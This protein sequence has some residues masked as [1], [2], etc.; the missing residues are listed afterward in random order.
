[1]GTDKFPDK[2][3]CSHTQPHQLSHITSYG[4][5]STNNA[6]NN[7]TTHCTSH[8]DWSGLAYISERRL[9]RWLWDI[10]HRSRFSVEPFSEKEKRCCP[11]R[12]ED[13]HNLW[14]DWPTNWRK[15]HQSHLLG[16]CC[17]L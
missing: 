6:A 11:N 15:K 9:P 16:L 2:T 4:Y 12:T 14:P 1:M 7:R 17:W 3:T 8:T 13:Q 5:A 10:Q